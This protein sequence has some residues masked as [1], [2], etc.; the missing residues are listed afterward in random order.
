MVDAFAF[1]NQQPLSLVWG[2]R[3]P[4]SLWGIT[5]ASALDVAGSVDWGCWWHVNLERSVISLAAVMVLEMFLW[6]G[7]IQWYERHKKKFYEPVENSSL[8][9]TLDLTLAGLR[10]EASHLVTTGVLPEKEADMKESRAGGSKCHSTL[11]P[12][13][14]ANLHLPSGIFSYTCQCNPLLILRRFEF[15]VCHLRPVRDLIDKKK[16]N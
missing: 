15:V 16:Q 2:G 10:A 6:S 13:I 11:T 7:Q 1:T 14:P 8:S 9:V 5:S 3:L 4:I 12:A